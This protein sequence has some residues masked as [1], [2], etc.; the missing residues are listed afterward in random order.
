MA[1]I[2][3]LAPV[4]IVVIDD[5]PLWRLGICQLL[6][7]RDRFHVIAQAGTCR[8][9]LRHVS[10]LKPDL[11]LLDLHLPDRTGLEVLLSVKEMSPDTRVAIVSATDATERVMAAFEN[12]ACGYILK[13]STEEE[14]LQA[15]EAITAGRFW[16]SPQLAGA[17]LTQ[18][19][20]GDLLPKFTERERAVF[21]AMARGLTN[22]EI[23][24]TLCL[25]KYTVQNYVSTIYNKLGISDRL[26][27][28]ELARRLTGVGLSSAGD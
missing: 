3:S 19:S 13:E 8:E 27:V 21:F 12:G 5:H 11:V 15:V 20:H 1:R 7:S 4:R 10:L 25:S 17:A 23:A 9:G 16:C 18:K 26:K 14:F 6:R 28:V 2:M 22:T 24:D